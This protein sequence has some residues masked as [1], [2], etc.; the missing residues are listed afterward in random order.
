MKIVNAIEDIINHDWDACES[1]LAIAPDN[2]S[3]YYV[4][5]TGPIDITIMP[6]LLATLKALSDA[7]KTIDDL[8]HTNSPILPE[9]WNLLYQI[10]NNAKAIIS[11]AEFLL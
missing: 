4:T 5:K 8:R 11:K 7:T 6:D 1:F 3:A 10:T 9:H 2:S